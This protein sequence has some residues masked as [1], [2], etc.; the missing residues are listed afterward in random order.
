MRKRSSALH[1]EDLA[2]EVL[3]VRGP[4]AGR[5]G[6]DGFHAAE[7]LVDVACGRLHLERAV[8]ARLAVVDTAEHRAAGG[9]QL[10][11]RALEHRRVGDLERE[12][13]VAASAGSSTRISSWWR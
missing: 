3:E 6:V 2:R 8:D 11:G 10:L 1:A 9:G 5:R 4:V 7:Q 12:V 13:L